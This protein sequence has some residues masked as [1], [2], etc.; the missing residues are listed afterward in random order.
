MDI[1]RM[2]FEEA[3]RELGMTEEELEQLVAAGEI[4]SLK[5]GDTIFFK[6]SVVQKFKKTRQA[7]S[8]T[9]LLSDDEIDLLGEELEIS[10]DEEAKTPQAAPA[11]EKPGRI[12]ISL[13][14]DLG[15]ED[16]DLTG[17]DR[18]AQE[19]KEFAPAG[20]AKPAAKKPDLSDD[21]TLLN[22][23]GLLE[24]DSEGTTPVPVA[25]EGSDSTL[26]DT[27]DILDIEGMGASSDPFA[28]DTVEEGSATELTEPGTL[29]RG[30]GARVM[31]MKRKSSHAPFT[32]VLAIACLVLLLPIGVVTNLLFV[33]Q[34]QTEAKGSPRQEAYGW[35]MEYNFLDSAVEGVAKLFSS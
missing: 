10:G 31:Q 14:D 12:E 28:A 1:E 4:A 16:L 11:G 32:V 23:D 6:K 15:L 26:L 21:E 34:P 20:K 5:E 13:D 18:A 2:S 22:L 30:G 24:E 27:D 3:S 25:A 19:T 33:H 7:G 35:I 9:I 17:A 29:L 8:P